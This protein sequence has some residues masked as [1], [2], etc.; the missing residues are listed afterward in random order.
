MKRR[1]KFNEGHSKEFN[2]HVPISSGNGLAPNKWQA[3]AWNNVDPSLWQ[4]LAW[5]GLIRCNIKWK[6][7]Q[8]PEFHSRG[9][10][11][12]TWINLIPAWIT[13]HMPHKVWGGITYSFPNFNSL[14][15]KVWEWISNFNPHFK[16]SQ[17]VSLQ[18]SPLLIWIY[19][20]P[21]MG[22]LLHPL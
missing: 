17:I 2:W 18:G 21:S 1:S 3:I 10:F 15:V 9:P 19:F 16:R 20:T 4:H 5:L 12:I 14:T 8:N 13:N 7:G 11:V 22:K 6:F